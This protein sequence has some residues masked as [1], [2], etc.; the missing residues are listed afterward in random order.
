[1]GMGNKLQ[2]EAP[3]TFLQSRAVEELGRKSYYLY[4]AHLNMI[5]QANTA[6]IIIKSAYNG[7]CEKSGE[8]F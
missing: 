4:A 2:S 7:Y 5:L 3:A 8:Y 6:A 1:M